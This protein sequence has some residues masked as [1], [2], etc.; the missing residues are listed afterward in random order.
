MKK[1]SEQSAA[2][3]P[4]RLPEVIAEPGLLVGWSLEHENKPRPIGFN[5]GDPDLSP[6]KGY[7]DPILFQGEGHL[8]TIAPTGAGKGIGCII[9][10]LL[11]YEGP[12]IV[13]DPKGENFAVTAKRRRDMGQQV[14][15]LDPMGITGS[16]TDTLNPL[17]IIDLDAP[18]SVDEVASLAGALWPDQVLPNDQFWRS[19]G[20]QLLLGLILHLLYDHEPENRNFAEARRLVARALADPGSVLEAMQKSRHP[21]AVQIA[22]MLRIPAE[23]T[24]GG[25]ISF[26]QEGVAFFRGQLVQHATA[27]TSFDLAAITQGDP[28]SVY[29]VMPPH[30]LETHGRLL[31][32]WITVMM[33]AIGRRRGRPPH[34][35]LF[36]LDEAAQLGTLPQL[37]QAITL[38]RG[39]GMQTWSF[40]QDVSQL[41][42]LYPDDWQTMINNC[43]VIQAFGPKNL[44]AAR[45]MCDLTGF[46]DAP[47]VLAMDFHE[48]LLAN[49]GDESVIARRPNYLSDPL[50]TGLYEANPFHGALQPD[51][52]SPRLPMRLYV[53]PRAELLKSL[54]AGDDT[55]V[56]DLLQKW[57]TTRPD[58][59][60]GDLS[61]EETRDRI[62]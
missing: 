22:S 18:A 29:I 11:R 41:K 12:V 31:R 59:S 57:A 54:T 60:D 2:Q 6:S 43:S 23:E 8:I 30:M 1:L 16:Q 21:E 9:P 42:R 56:Q 45:E 3:I 20:N 33:I 48:M 58:S 14:V 24:L 17:D 35:T 46:W 55:L 4:P 47:E 62:R 39:Y 26:A 19:R 5:Y 15:L 51:P 36:I 27:A 52:P 25:I 34:S 28:L 49:A 37:R 32:L 13:I 50:F 10:S 38:M 40:W 7:L 53:R 61:L 44:V